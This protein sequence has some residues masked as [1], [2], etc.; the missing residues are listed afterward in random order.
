LAPGI[1]KGFHTA[2]E[3][4]PEAGA[5][6]TADVDAVLPPEHVPHAMA[7]LRDAGF[8]SEYATRSGSKSEWVPPGHDGEVRSHELWHARN[9]WKLDVHDGLNFAAIMQVVQ[10]R[11]T[12]AFAEVL[13][14]GGVPLRV[15]DPNELISVLATHGSTEIYSQRL[16]RLVELVLVVRRAESLGRL[17][18]SEVEASLARR[19][20]R[21]FAYPLLTLVEQL[22][23]N[24]VPA[25][26]LARLRSDTTR[27]IREVTSRFTPTAPILDERFSL[28]ERLLWASGVRATARRF[29]RMI[30]PLE[31]ASL[32]ARWL[33]YRHR[34]TRVVSMLFGRPGSGDDTR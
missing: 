5:R 6:P 1:I 31:G 30:S 34:A 4:F 28:S 22:A 25:P 12:P 9:P 2:H 29:W 33:A 18:W 15:C 17:D 19:G 13:H 8:V 3:Y 11:Q 14:I 7:I 24:S 23:P 27:R 21:R 10:T 16:L 20:T 26:V 32:R